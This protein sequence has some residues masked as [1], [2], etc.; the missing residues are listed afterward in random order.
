VAVR[1]DHVAPA[2]TSPPAAGV[3]GV[4]ATTDTFRDRRRT[5]LSEGRRRRELLSTAD[6]S[7]DPQF[8]NAIA[9]ADRFWGPDEK[10]RDA[11]RSQRFGGTASAVP[12]IGS[13][14][15]A[16]VA[17]VEPVPVT[18][19]RRAGG[20]F[21]RSSQQD[22]M[23]GGDFLAGASVMQL[24]G[25]EVAGAGTGPVLPR[26]K[27]AAR[28][29]GTSLRLALDPRGPPAL[30]RDEAGRGRWPCPPARAR[31][32]TSQLAG[33]AQRQWLVVKRP[34]GDRSLQSVCGNRVAFGDG[35]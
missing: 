29:C 4:D 6:P 5:C 1:A 16:E 12:A 10:W 19:V 13:V 30:G 35:H 2:G 15:A 27:S 3:G 33:T 21:W 23:R 7:A 31:H 25:R 20:G 28:P 22:L 34:A 8:I 32:L 17:A 14:D 26:V 18:I 9:A 11:L 24:V